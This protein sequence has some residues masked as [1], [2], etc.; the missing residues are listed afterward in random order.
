M[1]PGISTFFQKFIIHPEFIIADYFW[2]AIMPSRLMITAGMLNANKII[3]LNDQK[4]TIFG[5]VAR[6]IFGGRD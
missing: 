3:D 5:D 6:A 4:Y 2:A 1:I